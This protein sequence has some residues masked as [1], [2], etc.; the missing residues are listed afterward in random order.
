MRQSDISDLLLIVEGSG[1]QD[2]AMTVAPLKESPA[3]RSVAA[4]LL[5]VVSLALKIS[6]N[7]LLIPLTL[8]FLGAKE[9]GLWIVLMTVGNC[10]A[11]SEMG[12][13]QTILNFQSVAFARGDYRGVNRVLTTVFGL[14]WLIVIPFGALAIL[15]IVFTSPDHWLIKDVPSSLAMGVKPLLVLTAVLALLRVPGNVFL[16]TLLGVRELA[17]RQLVDIVSIIALTVVTAVVLFLGGGLL[18]LVIA[19]HLVWILMPLVCYPVAKLRHPKLELHVRHWTPSILWPLFSNSFFFFLYALGLLFQR[20]GGNLL[21]GKF[22][23]LADVP[24]LFALLTLF[25]IVGWALADIISQTLQ[26]YII[27]LEVQG[28]RDRVVFF[29]GL[30]TKLTFVLAA[31]YTTLVL[32]FAKSGIELWLGP[33][34]SLGF[35][36]LALLAGSFLI[37]VL[38]LATNNFM[39]GFNQHRALSIVMAVYAVLSFVLAMIGARWW[40]PHNP[41]YGLCWGLF[42]SSVAGQAALLPWLTQR[43]LRIPWPHY[44]DQFLARP[45]LIGICGP[46]FFGAIS[47]TTRAAG[48]ALAAQAITFAL[49]IGLLFWFVLLSREEREW[50]AGVFVG[51]GLGAVRRLA[52]L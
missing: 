51:R 33:G 42:W 6:S 22:A 49:C 52:D 8:S 46:V 25:R 13:G 14:Y 26:P 32:L 20:F 4:G 12:I 16:A 28:R 47:Q 27:M 40:T 36:P 29:A 23:G 30:C 48:W 31:S 45:L 44:L 10:L 17:L 50:L 19:V 38:F 18:A 5:S 21:A 34:M 41:I 35:G 24:S 37:D 2:S 1:A 3:R 39:R 43:L 11:L 9:Y 15:W 7:L